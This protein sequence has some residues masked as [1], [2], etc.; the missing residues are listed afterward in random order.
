[1]PPPNV[2]FATAEEEINRISNAE[3]AKMFNELRE[4][5]TELQEAV[6]SDGGILPEEED[7]EDGL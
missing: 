2:R 5:L 6:E 1:V 7:S 3:V 4:P